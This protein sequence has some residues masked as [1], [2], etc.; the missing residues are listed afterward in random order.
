MDDCF[1]E[2]LQQMWADIERTDTPTA[3]IGVIN[4]PIGAYLLVNTDLIGA[5]R[6]RSACWMRGLTWKAGTTSVGRFILMLDHCVPARVEWEKFKPASGSSSSSFPSFEG[7]LTLFLLFFQGSKNF[8]PSSVTWTWILQESVLL[9]VSLTGSRPDS[10]H[11]LTS[12]LLQGWTMPVKSAGAVRNT[13]IMVL[14]VMLKEKIPDFHSRQVF[15]NNIWAC[16]VPVHHPQRNVW[17]GL[18][19]PEAV[20]LA[21]WNLWGVS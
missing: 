5:N 8:L 12:S 21:Q 11:L 1:H 6:H 13:Y 17:I 16:V 18:I 19:A 4:A 7:N 2:R 10:H 20:D 14:T 9:L 15:V 3:P